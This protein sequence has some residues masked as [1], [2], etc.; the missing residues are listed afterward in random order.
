MAA[1]AFVFY[2]AGFETTASTMAYCLL[3]LAAN[4]DVQDKLRQEIL[5]VITENNGKLTY[6]VIK[7]LTYM[8]KVISGKQFYLYIH[9]FVADNTSFQYL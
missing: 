6:D 8:D 1:N 9:V 3:E 7:D 5:D 4:L 2:V